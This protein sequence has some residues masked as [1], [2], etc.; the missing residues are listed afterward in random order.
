MAQGARQ[1]VAERLTA[2]RKRIMLCL[3]YGNNLLL[4]NTASAWPVNSL[5]LYLF[6]VPNRSGNVPNSFHLG[7]SIKPEAGDR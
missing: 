6:L 7:C 3:P 5:K 4:K 2:L 1:H